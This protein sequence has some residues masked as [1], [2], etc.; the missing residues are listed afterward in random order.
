MLTH[1]ASL[2]LGLCV[3]QPFALK[4]KTEGVYLNGR[5]VKVKNGESNLFWTDNWWG[6]K[7][8]CFSPPVLYEL[9]VEKMPLSKISISKGGCLA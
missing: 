8:L 7:P 5:N 3:T 4:S 2:F 1:A 6:E 9:C